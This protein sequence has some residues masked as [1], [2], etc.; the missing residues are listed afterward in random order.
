MERYACRVKIKGSQIVCASS[1]QC[2]DCL[3]KNK[4]EEMDIFID[5]KYQGVESCMSHDRF[6][7]D[8]G[9]VKQTGW[10]SR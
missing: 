1:V 5:G 4:C 9:K 2:T 3:D 8:K 7:R 10:G 6:K